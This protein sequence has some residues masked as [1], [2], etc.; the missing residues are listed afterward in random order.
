MKRTPQQRV[1]E[2]NALAKALNSTG[3]NYHMTGRVMTELPPHDP[4]EPRNLSEV[5]FRHYPGDS[6]GFNHRLNMKNG[7]GKAIG[8]IAW[9]GRSGRVESIQVHHDYQGLGVATSL[10]NQA[11]RLADMGHAP[12]PKHSNDRTISGDAWSEKVGGKRPKLDK[13]RA[14]QNEAR[15]K[16]IKDFS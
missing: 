16:A 13:R 4:A 8:H 1:D 10:W 3:M 14:A 7:D 9:N 12:R 5:Q 6:K 11:N 2:H 15:K